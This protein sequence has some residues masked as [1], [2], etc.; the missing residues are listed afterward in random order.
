MKAL[1][2]NC[3]MLDEMWSNLA[4]KEKKEF[5]RNNITKV[6]DNFSENLVNITRIS[7]KHVINWLEITER[8]P[9]EEWG[10][11]TCERHII[12]YIVYEKDG[13]DGIQVDKVFNNRPSA[14]MYV[15]TDFMV[16]KAKNQAELD[17]LCDLHIE[18]YNV[19]SMIDSV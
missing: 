8:L 12:V 13:Y 17:K 6:P 10:G 15:V 16:E 14:R 11:G 4:S 9:K 5:W 2:Y 1:K 7:S 19:L 3:D 18:E